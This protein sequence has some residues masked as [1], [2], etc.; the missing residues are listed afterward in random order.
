[1]LH[2]QLDMVTAKSYKEF[3]AAMSR[4][5]VPTFN[6]SYADRDGTI[7]HLQRHRAEAEVGRHRVLAR[8]GA[9]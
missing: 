7:E 8:A 3:T 2:Q 6:I 1:M 9:R 4:L 5:Q